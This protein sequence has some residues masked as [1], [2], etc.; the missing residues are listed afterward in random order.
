MSSL[1]ETLHALSQLPPE[2]HRLLWENTQ[3]INVAKNKDL[4]EMGQISRQ[5][6]FL[7]SGVARVYYYH[8]GVDVTDYFAVEGQ[9]IGGF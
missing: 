2:A 5:L 7:K 9:F 6:Y 3:L 8:K 1:I 4:L